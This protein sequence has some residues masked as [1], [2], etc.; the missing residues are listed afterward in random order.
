M[1][2]ITLVTTFLM[3]ATLHVF[4]QNEQAST[5]NN[6]TTTTENKTEKKV[7]KKNKYSGKPYYHPD[8]RTDED[9]D[10][11]PN[12]NDKCPHTPKGIKVNTFGCP[13]DTDE[14]GI[15][16][17][18]DNCPTEWGPIA[19]LGC[20]WGDKDKDGIYDDRDKCPDTPGIIRF[21]GCPDT[22]G[23]GIQDS[24]DQC[25]TVPGVREY[26][27]CP[28]VKKDTDK[29]G[30]YDDEDVC[31]NEPGIP[32]NHGCP[33]VLKMKEA[34]EEVIK[35]L[36]F[37]FA[38]ATIRETSYPSLNK[39]AVQLR[40]N[41]GYKLV[42]EG[43]TDNVGDDDFNLQLSRDRADA[44]RTYLVQW[45]ITPDRITTNGFGET[46][47][48]ATNTTDEGRQMNRR[49]DFTVKPE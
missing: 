22:D 13:L 19:N 17:Y 46:K 4:S 33:P 40:Q 23:D 27:G 26:R 30:I 2:K 47:P 49:V 44:V 31:P 3:F 6:T 12:G 34:I 35:N 41:P 20:P 5:N 1:R 38:K 32:E 28:P 16:D 10:G 36:N 39:L 24:E 29:D 8:F 25:P 45:G 18:E 37:D 11:V 42:I 14:D 7:D 43:H 15:Y 48:V 9:H 21:M